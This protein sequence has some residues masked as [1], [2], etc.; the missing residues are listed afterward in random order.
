MYFKRAANQRF[1]QFA[2]GLGLSG[3]G[4]SP[5]G[6]ILNLNLVF[7]PNFFGNFCCLFL[8][9]CCCQTFFFFWKMGSGTLSSEARKAG[10]WTS[11]W[12][13]PAIIF[14]SVYLSLPSSPALQTSCSGPLD[15]SCQTGLMDAYLAVSYT[16]RF[17]EFGSSVL[18]LLR[19]IFSR[20]IVDSLVVWLDQRNLFYDGAVIPSASPSGCADSQPRITFSDSLIALRIQLSA[21]HVGFAAPF[22]GWRKE[23]SGLDSFRARSLDTILRAARASERVEVELNPRFAHAME[24]LR[25][26]KGA[27]GQFSAE[28]AG[29][30]LHL[31][32]EMYG[33]NTELLDSVLEL[34]PSAAR[35]KVNIFPCFCERSSLSSGIVMSP[36][37]DGMGWLPLHQLVMRHGYAQDSVRLLVNYYPEAVRVRTADGWLPLHLLCRYHGS[38]NGSA[39]ILLEKWPDAVYE[40]NG[41]GW[42]ALHLLARYAGAY[43]ETLH[44]LVKSGPNAVGQETSKEGWLPLHFLVYFHPTAF[45]GLSALLDAFPEAAS[46]VARVKGSCSNLLPIV[47]AGA[48]DEWVRKRGL[49]HDLRS[50]PLPDED[51]FPLHMLL[52]RDVSCLDSFQ[53]LLSAYPAALLSLPRSLG[54][55]ALSMICARSVSGG[56]AFARYYSPSQQSMHFESMCAGANESMPGRSGFLESLMDGC[57][58][59]SAG[60]PRNRS[61]EGQDTHHGRR[62]A[63]GGQRFVGAVAQFWS[64]C[65]V[66]TKCVLCGAAVL[67]WRLRHQAQNSSR[68][69]G[70]DDRGR[71]RRGKGGFKKKDRPVRGG[72]RGSEGR[73]DA[74]AQ[75]PRA[76]SKSSSATSAPARAQMAAAE[77]AR[78]ASAGPKQEKSSPKPLRAAQPRPARPSLDQLPA[79][80]ELDIACADDPWRTVGNPS[81]KGDRSAHKAAQ[82][83]GS[84]HAAPG[85]TAATGVKGPRAAGPAEA[86]VPGCVRAAS[87]CP[88]AVSAAGVREEA[89]V[90]IAAASAAGAAAPHDERCTSQ[91]PTSEGGSSANSVAGSRPH[92]PLSSASGSPSGDFA[93]TVANSAG[94]AGACAGALAWA[95]GFPRCAPGPLDV[96]AGDAGRMSAACSAAKTVGRSLRA[97]TPPAAAAAAVSRGKEAC[98]GR[99]WS[100]RPVSAPAARAWKG[101]A[102]GDE[103]AEELSGVAVLPRGLLDTEDAAADARGAAALWDDGFGLLQLP[104]LG[105]SVAAARGS[106]CAAAAAGGGLAGVGPLPALAPWGEALSAGAA[107]AAAAAAGRVSRR[108]PVALRDDVPAADDCM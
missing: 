23:S 2:Q 43:N 85:V 88:A 78:P 57:A 9:F 93:R 34:H 38:A 90:A 73:A 15:P 4:T 52:S 107:A 1:A 24:L 63:S 7:P 12:V 20:N 40:L 91:G 39:A 84:T 22:G 3:S 26:P 10:A 67:A 17:G 41:D 68:L 96:A 82:G 53:L 100:A 46:S 32:L 61:R 8:G 65:S 104:L 76:G 51:L 14:L 80:E 35:H 108:F 55:R 33:N 30:L 81:S 45:A 62:I 103:P 101:P 27:S 37:Q 75:R 28:V 31:F 83:K 6:F 94:G 58:S 29:P 99:A 18:S 97:S 56:D 102:G 5:S 66:W 95:A 47:A 49:P 87:K 72:S 59:C 98:T 77:D 13:F 16:V 74:A 71:P 42:L 92:T 19:K 70:C 54:A 86:L 50:R 11:C 64:S 105:R 36:S 89:A 106:P 60:P 48:E 21:E 69:D 25:S 44:A 79:P